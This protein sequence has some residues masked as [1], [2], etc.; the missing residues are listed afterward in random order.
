[1]AEFKKERE[2]E[3]AKINKK[4]KHRRRYDPLVARGFKSKKLVRRPNYLAKEKGVDFGPKR[5][6]DVFRMR[7]QN[8]SRPPSM[9]V[10]DFML[11]E[12]AENNEGARRTKVKNNLISKISR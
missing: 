10:D 6:D 5:T 4:Y 3:I 2:I 1:M 12:K 11:L 8:T 7:K 9:H